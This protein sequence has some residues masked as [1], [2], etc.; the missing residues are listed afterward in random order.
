MRKTA[1][2]IHPLIY[3]LKRELRTRY[4]DRLK[5]VVL[6]GSY[7]RNQATE[8][9]DIDLLVVLENVDNPFIESSKFAHVAWRLSLE[10]D[11]V[12]S[13]VAVDSEKFEKS[14]LPVFALAREEGIE[15]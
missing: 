3:E 6:Y 2:E 14:E 12:I 9:S 13:A 4:G 5:A 7:A 10:N 8:E 15:I 11:V 1:N